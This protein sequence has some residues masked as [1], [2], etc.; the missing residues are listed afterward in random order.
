[1]EIMNPH[2]YRFYSLLVLLYF[3]DMVL[4]LANIWNSLRVT[5]SPLFLGCIL[6][7]GVIFPLILKKLARGHEQKSI[8]LAG[9]YLRRIIV[10]AV[11]LVESL[12]S[13]A[14]TWIG[15]IITSL[16]IGYLSLLTL[17]VLEAANTKLVLQGHISSQ[18][19]SRTMQTIVQ[20]GSFFGAM[21]SGYLLLFLN[22][23]KLIAL[24]CIFDII[25]SATARFIFSEKSGPTIGEA[26][27]PAH[28]SGKPL[29]RSLIYLC[30]II[31]LVGL[32]ISAFNVLT[33]IIFQKVKNL[34]S[35]Y[36]GL[37]SA[38]AGLGAFS[39]AFINIGWFRFL[40]PAIV[41]LLADLI[42][43]LSWHPYMAIVAC[44]FIGFSINT[45]RIH[46]RKTV[47]D[48]TSSDNEADQVSSLS[49]L[50][51]TLA[52]SI[53]PMVFGILTGKAVLGAYSAIYLF[54]AVALVMFVWIV[55]VRSS[56]G[57]TE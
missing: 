52:Q 19:A 42:F 21:A 43:T 18:M 4:L 12:F 30:I 6:S 2:A 11:I 14:D 15:F 41:L 5:N 49:A 31:A 25:V 28:L 9:L 53:G 16:C 26:N 40:I 22:Y 39:A 20:L 1:M 57:A 33:P 37:C 51:Y 3:S 23:N 13:I 34:N 56:S 7:I 38:V 45:I 17:T 10:F 36:F 8:S 29:P 27:R 54:P 50:M 46:A 44:L 32:H 47:I 55:L 35:E 24:I 48:K